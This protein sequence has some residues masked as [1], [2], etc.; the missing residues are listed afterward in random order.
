MKICKE[1]EQTTSICPLCDDRTKSTHIRL[2][3]KTIN[4][5]EVIDEYY[6]CN[7]CKVM[8]K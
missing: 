2:I 6:I 4:L 1:E 3:A 8:H 5:F 7:D